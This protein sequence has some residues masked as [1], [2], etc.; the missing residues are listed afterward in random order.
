[1]R[2]FRWGVSWRDGAAEAWF[3]VVGL[4]AQEGGRDSTDLG[5]VCERILCEGVEELAEDDDGVELGARESLGDVEFVLVHG[6]PRWRE[7]VEPL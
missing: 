4:C 3:D 7:N 6:G 1:V 5:V 2:R